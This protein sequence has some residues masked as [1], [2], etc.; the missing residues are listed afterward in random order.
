M[1][2]LQFVKIKCKCGHL[3]LILVCEVFRVHEPI[4]RERHRDF[5]STILQEPILTLPQG[6]VQIEFKK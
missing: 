4:R 2:K 1:N 5:S 6:E 3:N